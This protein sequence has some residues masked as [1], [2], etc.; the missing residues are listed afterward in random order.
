MRCAG[1]METYSWGGSLTPP[2]NYHAEMSKLGRTGRS[3]KNSGHNLV[4]LDHSQ[5][6]RP[7]CSQQ[8][9]GHSPTRLFPPGFPWESPTALSSHVACLRMSFVCCRFLGRQ[10]SAA[11]GSLVTPT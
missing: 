11:S 1:L 2:S 5:M 9:S 10:T 6:R 8:D 4:R 7:R 3:Q